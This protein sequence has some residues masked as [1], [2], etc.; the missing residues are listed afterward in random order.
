[1]PRA[2]E[3]LSREQ[4]LEDMNAY[5]ARMER[6]IVSPDTG[7]SFFLIYSQGGADELGRLRELHSK[8][9]N[10]VYPLVR[11]LELILRASGAENMLQA[12]EDI[13]LNLV[14]GVISQNETLRIDLQDLA[15]NIG[16]GRNNDNDY[17]RLSAVLTK[18]HKWDYLKQIDA[19]RQ[20]F[21]VTGKI[22]L[23]RSLV[24]FLIENLPGAKEDVDAYKAQ[25]TML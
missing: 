18:L 9:L 19:D 4:N 22:D 25:G 8:M 6:A 23:Y 17:S 15:T 21:R 11:F 7:G 10:E 2:Y 3:Y 14:W 12:G 24:D 20:I 16:A 1:M 5:F 13:H